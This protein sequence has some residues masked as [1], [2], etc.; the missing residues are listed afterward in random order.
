MRKKAIILILASMVAAV[1]LVGAGAQQP[2][3]TWHVYLPLVFKP[4]TPPP[5][6]LDRVNYYR[7]YFA[8][9][10]CP[11][12]EGEVQEGHFTGLVEHARYVVKNDVLTHTE[13][14]QNPWYS[15]EGLS[16]GQASNLAA[17]DTT[18]VL[19]A[20]PVDVMMTSPFHAALILSP[21]LQT[22]SYGEYSE[23][24]GGSI[25]F[26]AALDVARGVRYVTSV[27]YQR[28]FPNPLSSGE[29]YPLRAM[30][31]PGVYPDPV[32]TCGYSGVVGAPIL[33]F[34]DPAQGVPQVT[35]T[36]LTI[37]GQA[38]AHCVYTAA[39]YTA[40]D[41]TQQSLGRD[42]LRESGAVVILPQAPLQGGATYT[43]S[44]TVNG[45]TYTW[46]FT[47]ANGYGMPSTYRVAVGGG[48]R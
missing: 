31:A 42:I 47:T 26:A 46:S 14:S 10:N 18:A 13:D 25:Q 24:T 4:S 15:I 34:F 22:S 29:A 5:G 7:C 37:G 35:S 32:S 27:S 45:V 20:W 28:R 39:T 3:G 43:V 38:V 6:G 44:A 30:Y 8:E 19:P 23:A 1:S 21:W 48:R 33:L 36:S 40:P 12:G 11:F 9:Y 2:A 41:A 17:F 16:A